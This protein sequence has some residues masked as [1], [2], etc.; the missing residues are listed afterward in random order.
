M[1]NRIRIRWFDL[2]FLFVLLLFATS[3]NYMWVEGVPYW[4]LA[5]LFSGLI[6]LMPSRAKATREI[7]VSARWA[8]ILPWILYV[9][10]IATRDAT[11]GA[12]ASS[13]T[14]RVILNLSTLL[15]FI[16]SAVFGLK[17]HWRQ[18][19][20][21]VSALGFLYGVV[22]LGQF[23]GSEFMWR[24]PDLLSSFSSRNVTETL[25]N[26]GVL[27]EEDWL[28]G[29]A[30]V[31][32]SRGLDIFVHKF[33]AYQGIIAGIA[34]AFALLSWQLKKNRQNVSLLS[35]AP[36]LLFALVSTLGVLVTFSRAPLLGITLAV[37][38]T[39]WYS[40]GRLKLVTVVLVILFSLSLTIVALTVELMEAA[41]FGRLF[42][43]GSTLQSDSSRL[44]SWSYSFNL[45]LSNPLF[46]AGTTSMSSLG[47]STHNVPLRIL[48]DF[49]LIG[50]SFYI[51]VWWAI[52]KNA[53]KAV[54][55]KIAESKM[56]GIVVLAAIVVAIVDNFT[57]SSGLLQRDISQAALLGLC[58]GLSISAQRMKHV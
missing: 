36:I 10:V 43:I 17:C 8:I 41:Q 24:L 52:I 48:G 55:M 49:G 13:F 4:L 7:L 44:E 15:L 34:V 35:I 19:V 51:L 57:H 27:T 29:F 56:I 12:L 20:Q 16:V 3:L 46:G 50:F 14:D 5:V 6:L 23:A 38:L 21:L 45:F 28:L 25:F 37:L 58:Y 18:I 31:G 9:V 30:K 32:R 22:A 11:T 1:N 42:D 33:A 26:S 2:S 54:R 40:Q 39:L 47:I 53:L